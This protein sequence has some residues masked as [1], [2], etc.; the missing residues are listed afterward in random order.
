DPG[1][2]EHRGGEGGAYILRRIGPEGDA[3]PW[4]GPNMLVPLYYRPTMRYYGNGYTV[5]YRFVPVYKQDSIN[6]GAVG[7]SSNFRTEAFHMSNEEVLSWGANSPRMTVKDARTAAPRTAVTSIV[8]KKT[9]T[10]TSTKNPETAP[11]E[12]AAPATPA[13][14]AA[15][16]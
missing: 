14:D 2:A 16:A 15:P 11:T 7:G 1:Y 8:R 13:P 6:I 10:R 3:T 9:T 12:N 5:N 4:I